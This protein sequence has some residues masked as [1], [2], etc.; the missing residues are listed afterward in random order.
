MWTSFLNRRSGSLKE[1]STPI[2]ETSKIDLLRAMDL[3]QDLS[4]EEIESLMKN[5][6]MTTAKKGAVFYRAK[7]G[8]EVLFMLK[9]GKVELYRQSPEGRKLTVAIVEQGTF[10][11]VM[12]LVGQQHQDTYA[13][14]LEDSAVCALSR[15]DLRLLMLEY[16]KVAFRIVEVLAHRL[17]QTRNAL[18][19]MVFSDITGRV[20]S[21]LLR[22]ADEETQV[23]EGYSHQDLASM[24]GCLRESFTDALYRFKK[25]KALAVSR[26]RIEILDRSQLESVITQRADSVAT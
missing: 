1:G 25:S 15:H 8:P 2:E 10:F 14:A 24:V 13:V 23:I 11:G 7:D 9:S 19:E 16:P 6:P 18:Q 20:A 4:K 21:L 17:E 5:T 22:L 12:P 3:F 26:R